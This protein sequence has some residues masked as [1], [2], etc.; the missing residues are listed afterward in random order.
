MGVCNCSPSKI[1]V[2][3]CPYIEYG[4][5]MQPPVLRIDVQY[6]L[7]GNA[8]PFRLHGDEREDKAL[9]AALHVNAWEEAADLAQQVQVEVLQHGGEEQEHRVVLHCGKREV[10]PSEVVVLHVEVLLRGA[11]LVVLVDDLFLRVVVVVGQY[12]AVHVFHSGQELL[13]LSGL[14]FGALHD[15]P[16]VPVGEETGEREGRDVHVLPIDRRVPPFLTLLIHFPAFGVAGGTEVE[17][18]GTQ[19]KLLDE[20]LGE[21]DFM[22]FDFTI[23]SCGLNNKVVF[24]RRKDLNRDDYERFYFKKKVLRL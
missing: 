9:E 14:Y 10:R 23:N 6:P 5:I 15:K 16:Q 21:R 2:S 18:I 13:S 24:L 20:F 7:P 1:S 3:A 4:P 12:G 8:H 19:E 11:S 17:G 22:I